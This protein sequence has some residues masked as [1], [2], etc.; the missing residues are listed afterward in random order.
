MTNAAGFH[1]LRPPTLP[2]LILPP[3]FVS[4]LLCQFPVS[5]YN[6]EKKKRITPPLLPPG[7]PPSVLLLFV[8]LKTG[9]KS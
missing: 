7:R 5:P 1:V 9:K 8:L 3:L 6:M 4:V 2:H